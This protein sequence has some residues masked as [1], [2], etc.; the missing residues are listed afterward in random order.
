MVVWGWV[1]LKSWYC[2][3]YGS[4]ETFRGSFRPFPSHGQQQELGEST[5]DGL[6]LKRHGK[7]TK[8]I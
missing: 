5:S 6:V 3:G 4:E 8:C 1:T 7:Y 2:E